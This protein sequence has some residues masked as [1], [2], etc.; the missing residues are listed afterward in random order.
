MFQSHKTCF[1]VDKS[2]CSNFINVPPTLDL[3]QLS[4]VRAFHMLIN[5][6]HFF[7]RS[8]IYDFFPSANFGHF[9]SFLPV[10]LGIRLD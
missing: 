10:V 1:E 4:L 8:D 2:A 6:F 9:L 3:F 5:L 7:F